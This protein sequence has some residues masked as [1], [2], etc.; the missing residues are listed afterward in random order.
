MLEIYAKQYIINN[1]HNNKQINLGGSIMISINCLFCNSKC[2]I[3]DSQINDGHFYICENCGR[4]FTE[5][6]LE[7]KLDRYNEY[8]K[9]VISNFLKNRDRN[10]F[11]NILTVEYLDKILKSHKNN[12]IKE[13]SE[14]LDI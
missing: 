5:D 12:V 4:Y 1:I 10:D 3:A 9:E 8:D 7:N 14:Y 6:Y 13:V 2:T 11:H